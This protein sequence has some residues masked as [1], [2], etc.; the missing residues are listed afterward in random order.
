[1]KP[2]FFS[3]KNEF[4]LKT[5]MDLDNHQKLFDNEQLKWRIQVVHERWEIKKYNKSR[6]L[7]IKKEIYQKIKKRCAVM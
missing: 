3:N 6:N 1:M 2:N 4:Y 7:S 5:F